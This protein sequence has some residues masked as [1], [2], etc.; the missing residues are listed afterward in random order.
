MSDEGFALSMH[1]PW[2]SLLVAGIKQ[3]VFLS[4]IHL[5]VTCL[6]DLFETV[7]NHVVIHF[8]NTFVVIAYYSICLHVFHNSVN[9]KA[10]VLCTHHF[11]YQTFIYLFLYLVNS[12]CSLIALSY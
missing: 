10:V 7:D 9:P 11:D 6:R 3:S 2:A 8:S 5:A 1:Q 4:I 12:Y